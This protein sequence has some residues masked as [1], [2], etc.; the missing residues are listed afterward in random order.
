MLRCDHSATLLRTAA[1]LLLVPF[2]GTP[3]A[4]ADTT[5]QPHKEHKRDYKRE[6]QALEEQ[7][8]L[9]QVNGDVA[10]MERLL[11]P[12]FLGI[13]M[14]GQVAD[15]AQLLERMRNRNLVLTKIIISDQKIKLVGAVAI[16]TSLAQIEGTNESVPVNG[17]YRYT[18]IYRRYPDGTWKVTNFEVTPTR[19]AETG[20]PER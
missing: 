11:A 3:P 15:R 1:L 4:T 8:R 19:G 7:W 10:T 16:V 14:T 6:I 12:D 20:P 17:M 5:P 13:S 2:C 18:R 9:A